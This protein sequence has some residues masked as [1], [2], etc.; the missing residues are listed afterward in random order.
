MC[1]SP[2]AGVWRGRHPSGRVWVVEWALAHPLV[3]R[4]C[5]GP[6]FLQSKEGVGFPS[7]D[8]LH[9]PLTCTLS[10]LPK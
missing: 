2:G 3:G 7:F 10:R 1:Y 4:D 5:I 8:Q 6:K 9:Y